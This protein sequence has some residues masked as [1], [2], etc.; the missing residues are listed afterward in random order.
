MADRPLELWKFG[1][2]MCYGHV[3]WPA[4]SPLTPN[5]NTI[6][7]IP[8]FFSA[9]LCHRVLRTMSCV[10]HGLTGSCVLTGNLWQS[11]VVLERQ[12]C[13]PNKNWS[14]R[15]KSWERELKLIQW[16]IFELWCRSHSTLIE[17]GNLGEFSIGFLELSS[18]IENYIMIRRHDSVY[19]LRVISNLMII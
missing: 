19:C 16:S 6:T 1:I 13:L 11:A 4:L 5:A 15:T 9:F 7:N 12:H 14:N 10:D 2:T 18:I 17:P 3:S 8:C